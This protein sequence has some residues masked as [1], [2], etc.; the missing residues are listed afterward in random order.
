MKNTILTFI[1]IFTISPLF[2]S[3][4]NTCF[5][6]SREDQTACRERLEAE[7]RR[8]AQEDGVAWKH[9][10]SPSGREI[11]CQVYALEDTGDGGIPFVAG[12]NF[13]VTHSGYVSRYDSRH[14]LDRKEMSEEEA[15]AVMD[16]HPV[17]NGLEE[18]P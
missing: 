6:G 2:A 1:T 18:A 10:I 11:V 16:A 9:A 15:I 8:D 14:W 5:V 4:Q 7:M 17:C 13:I 12:R 3:A